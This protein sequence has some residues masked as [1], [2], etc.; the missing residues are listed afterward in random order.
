MR[1]SEGGVAIRPLFRI[2]PIILKPAAGAAVYLVA[3][4]FVI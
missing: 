1:A 3:V 2:I 4:F